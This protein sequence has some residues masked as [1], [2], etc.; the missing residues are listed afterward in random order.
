M[1]QLF[2]ACGRTS[3]SEAIIDARVHSSVVVSILDTLKLIRGQF[4]RRVPLMLVCKPCP[5][6]YSSVFC[7]HFVSYLPALLL[8]RV[9]LLYVQ[10]LL[11]LTRFDCIQT[12]VAKMTLIAINLQ[13]KSVWASIPLKIAGKPLSSDSQVAVLW[14][15]SLT[16]LFNHLCVSSS[17]RTLGIII[18][19]RANFPFSLNL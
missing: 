18:T 8:P 2:T 19:R 15:E 16:S 11:G 4:H 6:T 1:C 12:G 3:E 13:T 5:T 14:D 9:T 7:S 17:S 10:I